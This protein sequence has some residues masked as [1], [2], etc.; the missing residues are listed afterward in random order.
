MVLRRAPALGSATGAVVVELAAEP[1]RGGRT[2]VACR[3]SSN[4]KMSIPHSHSIVPRCCSTC[5]TAW[6]RPAGL[7][8]Q[9][10][11][12]GTDVRFSDRQCVLPAVASA[13]RQ[14]H[15]TR[16]GRRRPGRRTAAVLVGCAA[17]VA[18]AGGGWAAQAL[19]GNDT[20]TSS[21]VLL[22]E[23]RVAMQVPAHW[24]VQRITAGPGSARVQVSDPG[25][26]ALHLTQSV[27]DQPATLQQTAESL[28]IAM[29]SAPPGVFVDFTPNGAAA[30]RAAVTYRE[31]RPGSRT[32][33]AVVVDGD[34]RIAIGCQRGVR[35]RGCDQR[36]L[37]AGDPLGARGAV[38]GR[39]PQF[40]AR[41]NRS[42]TW[43]VQIH[44]RLNQ[45]RKD[46]RCRSRQVPRVPH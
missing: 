34:V 13:R 7:A 29:Q 35:A 16:A 1:G 19:S 24:T 38:K 32:D 3:G 41:R 43:C 11:D 8:Q 25:G 23:G 27:T 20:A 18:A 45:T 4:A 33:W 37:R 17:S 44:Q 28:R 15:G 30:G 22:V 10:R 6:L 39:Q 9:L 26:G 31:L 2:G 42:G 36:R 21:S 12:Q 14:A 46:P 5:P 40:S